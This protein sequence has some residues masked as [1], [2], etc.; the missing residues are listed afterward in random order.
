MLNCVTILAGGAGSRLWPASTLQVPKQFMRVASAKS[1]LLQTLQR[2]WSLNPSEGI[3]IIGN[4]D[5]LD[6]ILLEVS[7]LPA[8]E[9]KKTYILTEPEMRNTAPA[10]FYANQLVRELAGPEAAQLVLASDHLIDPV[11]ALREA[12]GKALPYLQR[13]RIFVFGIKPDFPATGY[14][15]IQRGASLSGDSGETCF[16]VERFLEKPGLETA[17]ELI[18]SPFYY[19]NSGMFLYRADLFDSELR[20]HCPEIPEQLEGVRANLL[21][22]ITVHGLSPVLEAS[23][24]IRRAYRNCKSIS[25]DYALMER[26]GTLAVAIPSFHWSDIGNWDAVSQLETVEPENAVQVGRSGNNY[27]RSSV[28]V[29]LCDVSDLIVVEQNGRLLIC[30]KGSS[31][32]V[33]EASSALEAKIKSSSD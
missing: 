11:S 4:R 9:Q 15:Y 25:I 8:E 19:W 26:S 20:R 10:L 18:A 6:L 1:L 21:E 29:A 33:K 22:K 14:G 28:P 31:E 5:H 32:K 7:Q 30:R 24:P 13:Q 12:V 27:I 17:R 2:A 23:E 16:T 3:L